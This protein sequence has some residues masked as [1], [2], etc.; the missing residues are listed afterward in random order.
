M[1]SDGG[2]FYTRR[3][4]NFKMWDVTRV[5]K[6]TPQNTQEPHKA[7]DRVENCVPPKF[8]VFINT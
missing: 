6:K 4:E 8:V 3:D 2:V 5:F 1:L 7:D